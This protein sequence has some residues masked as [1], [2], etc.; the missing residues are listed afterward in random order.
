MK[1]RKPSPMNRTPPLNLAGTDSTPSPTLRERNGTRWN[2]SLPDSGQPCLDRR[3][4]RPA[5]K[6]FIVPILLGVLAANICTGAAAVGPVPDNVR[7]ELELDPFY[8]KHTAVAGF[9]IVGST[10]VSDFALREAA[11]ILGHMLD[12]RDDILQTMATNRVRLAVMAWNEY[13]TD[14]PEQRDMRS[15]VFWDRRARGLG[16]SPVSCGEENL[17]CFPGDPYSTENLLI[18]E[19]AH[20]VHG[21]GLRYIDSTFNKRLRAAYDRAMEQGLWKGTYAAGNRQE[22]WAEGVQDWF[23]NNRE[24]DA[25][26]NQ[27][28]TRA[29]LKEYDPELAKLCAEVFGDKPWRYQKPMDREPAGRAHLA[30][31]DPARSPRFRWRQA[32]VPEDPRVLIQTALGDVEVELF[33]KQAPI[34]VTNFLRYVHDGLY[35]DGSFFRTVTMS[36]QPTNNVKIQVVQIQADP[37]KEEEFHP[38][39]VLERTR[40]T[41]LRHLDGTLSM[42]R[43]GPDTAQD[44]FSICIGDQPELD[45]GGKRNPDG[46]G[47]AAFGKVINGMDVAR[48]IHSSPADGQKLTPP[49][50]IQRAVRLN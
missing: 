27:V 15:K 4:W 23:D 35:A 1:T 47:F 46:Q 34:T 32:P 25:L 28:N 22:Y 29:E 10:N 18:H 37:A 48:K 13:T 43:D 26:H 9:S 31:F 16:G 39:I 14:L 38:P 50:R 3:Q 45:F 41:D 19:F 2:A 12:G 8:Q 7:Q 40:D 6:K 5:F 42:A 24:N 21:Y 30:G 20:A 36:N 33:P 11:W 17:L 49:I 44:S